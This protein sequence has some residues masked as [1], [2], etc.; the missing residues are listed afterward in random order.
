VLLLEPLGVR[1]RS[2][3]ADREVVGE[4]ISSGREH[5]RVPDRS[6]LEDR[7]VGRAAAD[8]DQGDAQVLLVLGQDRLGDRELLEHHVPHLDPRTVRAGHQVLDRGR[9]RRDDVDVRLE[10]HPVHPQGRGDA[11]LVVQHE[12]LR[13]DVQDLALGRDAHGA[14]G[15]HHAPH[16]V[17]ADRLVLARDGHDPA[18]VERAHVRPRDAE[19]RALDA[20]P[21]GQLRVLDGR[22]DRPPWRPG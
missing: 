8:V 17:A 12:L 9:R 21:R 20:D 14:R 3:Q 13:Q 19:R 4:V 15:L 2:T 22:L 6:L 10:T 5:R 18:A 16:V 7:E 1:D 11:H